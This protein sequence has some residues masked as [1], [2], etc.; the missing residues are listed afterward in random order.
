M[1][2]ELSNVITSFKVIKRK[3]KCFRCAQ[4]IGVCRRESFE[5]WTFDAD[6]FTLEGILVFRFSMVIFKYSIA[7]K[8]LCSNKRLISLECLILNVNWTVFGQDI[9]SMLCKS[10]SSNQ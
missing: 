5:G 4:P 7:D 8:A 6:I 1:L 9:G 3:S 2:D 10:M